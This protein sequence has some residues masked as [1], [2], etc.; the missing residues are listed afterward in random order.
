[1]TYE[2]IFIQVLAEATGQETAKWKK[3]LQSVKTSLPE[4]RWEEQLDP[5]QSER[6]LAGLRSES[7][8]ILA[9]LVRGAIEAGKFSGN[10]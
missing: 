2:D 1:M 3:V 8:G 9:W 6:L 5:E 10:A 4:G 7:S